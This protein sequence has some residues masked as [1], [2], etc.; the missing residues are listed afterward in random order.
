MTVN[1][2]YKTSGAK[3]Q[4]ELLGSVSL[5]LS[6]ARSKSKQNVASFQVDMYKS[7]L[8]KMTQGLQ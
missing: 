2:N 6:T 8:S 1:K 3:I 5:Q 7:M 4:S